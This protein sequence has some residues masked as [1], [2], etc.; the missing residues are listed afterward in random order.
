MNL[1]SQYPALDFVAI[2]EP[3]S[4]P[5]VAVNLGKLPR[6]TQTTAQG[7]TEGIKYA[8]KKLATLSNIKIYI[9]A[10]HGGYLGWCGSKKCSSSSDCGGDWCMKGF[11]VCPN[12]QPN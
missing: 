4:L 8:L 9:D 3:D 11:C 6:C 1:L 5:N 10:A 7:I 2:I 12:S